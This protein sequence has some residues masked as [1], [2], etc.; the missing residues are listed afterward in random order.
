M[1]YVKVFEN[2]TNTMNNIPN[3]NILQIY[4]LGHL[5]INHS[6]GNE[7]WILK[8]IFDLKIIAVYFIFSVCGISGLFCILMLRISVP[9]IKMTIKS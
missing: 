4:I 5:Y 8:Q 1:P 2:E 6:S 7:L 3:I 9:L